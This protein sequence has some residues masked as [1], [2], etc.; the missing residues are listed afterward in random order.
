MNKERL[1]MIDKY[2]K[3]NVGPIL[4]SN[5]SFKDVENAII[6]KS[7]IDKLELTGHYENTTY[8]PPKWYQEL[9][10]MSKTKYSLL[11]IEK[12]N[13]IPIE[14][15]PKFIEI[16]K[17]RKISTFKLPEN[18]CV[19]ATCTDLTTNKINEDVYTLLAHL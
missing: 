9:V 10:D 3:S 17:Y 12:I 13:E 1:E 11:V 18:C 2:I 7:N 16:L 19:V 14:E 5:V 4:I 8:C 15:Q 6:L